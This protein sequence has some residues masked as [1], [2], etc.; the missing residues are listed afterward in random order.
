MTRPRI[1]V[2]GC[3]A[4]LAVRFDGGGGRDRFLLDTVAPLADLVTFCPEVEAG[5][6]APRDTIRLVRRTRAVAPR[7]VVTRSG[8]DWT[9]RL[10]ATSGDIA[11]RLESE[12]LSGIVVRRNS[13]TCG[14]ERVRVYD[15][16]G[17]PSKEGVGLFTRVLQ[18]R[19]PLLAI[20]EDG[21]LNDPRI[22]E[23][24]FE[25]VFAH[26]RLRALFDDGDWTR[27]DV[28]RFHTAEK[29]LL[30]SH[31]TT[32]Y[33]QLGRLV[34]QVGVLDRKEFSEAYRHGFLSAMAEMATPGR[35]V[36]A[37][38]HAAGFIKN[39]AGPEEKARLTEAIDDYAAGLVPLVVPIA[40]IRS[41]AARRQPSWLTSQ[42]WFQPHPK[43]L[44]LRTW[45]P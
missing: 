28:V 6:G 10:T 31:S 20:E 4:G 39:D 19:F 24:F 36:N 35:Q 41:R 42:T 37:L 22:R 5:M 3:I 7:A 13:P 43:V 11:D 34:A 2:S 16:N 21:R 17:V 30:L 32:Q 40:V 45:T 33:R 27:G 1:G 38:Q 18:E 8:E 25:R 9:D 23:A 15:W 14:L 29:L 12:S 44:K 26:A